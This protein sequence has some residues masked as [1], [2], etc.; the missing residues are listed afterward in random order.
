MENLLWYLG[1]VLTA[2]IF[3][4]LQEEKIR[5]KQNREIERLE[6]ESKYKS[7]IL[8]EFGFDFVKKAV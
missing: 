7:Q 4:L 8:D 6:L 3:T 2:L 1:G 5:I